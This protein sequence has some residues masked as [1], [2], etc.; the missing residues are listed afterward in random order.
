MTVVTSGQLEALGPLGCGGKSGIQD[1]LS[2]KDKGRTK[3]SDRMSF[4][5]MAGAL[6]ILHRT[7]DLQAAE[8]ILNCLFV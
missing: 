6:L 4:I 1:R 7:T 8:R 5:L 2:G 3:D